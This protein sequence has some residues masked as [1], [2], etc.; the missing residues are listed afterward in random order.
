[1][2]PGVLQAGGVLVAPTYRL[3]P[4]HR[5]PA[6]LHDVAAAIAWVWT[7]AERLGVDRERIVVGGHS[8]GGH[9]SALATLHADALGGAGASGRIVKGCLPVSASFNLHHPNAAPGSGEGRVYKSLLARPEDDLVASPVN[10]LDRG[11]PP[12][13]IVYGER[14]Y[15][16]VRRTGREMVEAMRRRRYGVHV[17]EWVGADHF[18]TH[19]ALR[20][21][22][23]PW[24][25]TLRKAFAGAWESRGC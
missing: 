10:H 4:E 17:E 16:W 14:D 23:H 24:Y 25:E 11:A 19:L 18:E 2:A 22:R 5:F 21:P 20:D 8:A 1:M 7:N 12:F 13:H 6:Q 9:L 15:A 3:G